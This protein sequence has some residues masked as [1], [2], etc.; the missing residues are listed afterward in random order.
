MNLKEFCFSVFTFNPASLDNIDTE[1]RRLN[2]YTVLSPVLAFSGK[3]GGIG[4]EF[5][6]HFRSN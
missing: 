2:L 3:S 4:A 5:A 1:I 6:E